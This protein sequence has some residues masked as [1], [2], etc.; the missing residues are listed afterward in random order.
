MTGIRVIRCGTVIDEA[1][2]VFRIMNKT[3]MDDGGIGWVCL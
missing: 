3:Y 1:R 2:G